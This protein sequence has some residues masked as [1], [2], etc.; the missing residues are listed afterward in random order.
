M[1]VA[2]LEDE[3][4]EE[5][6]EAGDYIRLRQLLPT[7]ILFNSFFSAD[8]GSLIRNPGIRNF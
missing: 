5:E 2:Q 6:E 4:E 7:H 8:P 3:E 1:D